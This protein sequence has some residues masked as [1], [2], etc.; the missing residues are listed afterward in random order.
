ME[1]PALKA[2]I[3]DCFGV[4]YIQSYRHKEMVRNQA[5]L[6]ITQRLR[7]QY[8]I[9]LLSNMSESS[10]SRYFSEQ[11]RTALFDAVVLSGEVG[12]PKPHPDIFLAILDK[13]GF[14]AAETVFVDDDNTNVLSAQS[15]GMHAIRYV[16]TFKLF[17]ELKDL[18]I[19]L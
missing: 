6:D 9:G 2:I 10:M 14:S 17:S 18:G 7:K 5:L 8:R 19:E 15:L 16:D 4:L 12:M 3:F 1:A 11:E 13:L